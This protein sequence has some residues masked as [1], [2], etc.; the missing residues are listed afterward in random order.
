MRF[1][2]SHI[3]YRISKSITSILLL[4]ILVFATIDTHMFIYPSLSRTLISEVFI[5]LLS[6]MVLIYCIARKVNPICLKS[7]LFILVWIAYI[8]IH[9]ACSYPH[10]QYRTIYLAITLLLLPTVSLY[11]KLGNIS[12]TRCENILLVVAI[13][14]LMFVFAQWIG[15]FDSGNKYFT[16]TGSNENPTVTALYLVGCIPIITVRLKHECRKVQYAL[17]LVACMI[18]IVIL[19]CRTA[20]IGLG[21]EVFIGITYW[22]KKRNARLQRSYKYFVTLFFLVIIAGASI[23]LYNIKRDSAD[24]RLLIWKISTGMIIDRP[25]GYGYG[26]FDKYYNLHQAEYFE[27]GNGTETEKYHS[28]YVF[29][30]YN[31][32]IEQGI[33]GGIIGLVF[34]LLFYSIVIRKALHKQDYM[35]MSIFSAFAVMSL[36]NFIYSSIQPWYLLMIVGAFIITDDKPTVNYK[37]S[38]TVQTLFL[39]VT[40][41]CLWKMF[42]LT[43]SHM[44]LADY[45]EKM[46]HGERITKDKI[47]SLQPYIGTSEAYWNI[48]AYN[49]ILEGNCDIAIKDLNRALDLTSSPQTLQLEYYAYQ[50]SGRENKGIKFIHTQNNMMPMQLRPK[51]LLMEYYYRYGENKKALFYAKEIE[52]TPHKID[53]EESH[54]IRRKA[55]KFIENN[56]ITKQ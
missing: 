11:L 44:K 35:S 28:G 37:D 56:K 2:N 20:Y 46:I 15:F 17:F 42:L 24:G 43:R 1:V 5:L 26:L 16:L 22:F 4:I 10:E 29:M 12:R 49:N 7:N 18:T 48:S 40:L 19:R 6:A 32:Y 21:V 33:E 36:T 3:A 13:I 54:R 39:I 52:S 45:K 30:P 23:I 8:A 41:V 34:L 27:Q 51:F 53:N 14:H 50:Q 9:Y 38:L 25:Q 55:H 31:D 47:L